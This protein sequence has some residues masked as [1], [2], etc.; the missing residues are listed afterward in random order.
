MQVLGA[1][2]EDLLAVYSFWSR[3]L[4]KDPNVEPRTGNPK[5][6]VGVGQGKAYLCPET[7]T[8]FPTLGPQYIPFRKG[9]LRSVLENSELQLS[10]TYSSL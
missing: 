8:I 5:S 2:G 9:V 1:L 6:I 10:W 4:L 3:G 7:C